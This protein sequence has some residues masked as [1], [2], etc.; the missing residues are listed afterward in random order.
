MLAAQFILSLGGLSP[1][2]MPVDT[3][4]SA[5]ACREHDHGA[6]LLL[7]RIRF[8]TEAQEGDNAIVRDSLRLPS[9]PASAVHLIADEAVCYRAAR[10]YFGLLHRNLD[11]VSGRV[12]VVQAGDRYAV[13][14]PA[15]SYSLQRRHWL[16]AILD[17]EFRPLAYFHP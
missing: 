6:V 9:M 12:Y 2:S 13:V 7:A 11:T 3:P 14:D 16:V 1:A 8:Y 5:P 10:A 17:Q 4:Q 15:W